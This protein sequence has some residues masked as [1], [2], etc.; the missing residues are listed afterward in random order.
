MTTPVQRHTLCIITEVWKK[1][2]MGLPGCG[3]KRLT[4]FAGKSSMNKKDP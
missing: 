4:F 2:K 3:D 1:I